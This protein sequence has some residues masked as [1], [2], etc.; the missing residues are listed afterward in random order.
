MVAGRVRLEAAL[1]RL[2]AR[3]PAARAAREAARDGLRG[4]VGPGCE[5]VRME[6]QGGGGEGE[7]EQLRTRY[8]DDTALREDLPGGLAGCR[9]EFGT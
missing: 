1:G 5:G 8:E 6:G 3:E 7:G 2:A 4:C 9:D